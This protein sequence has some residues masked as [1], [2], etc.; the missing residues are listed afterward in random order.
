MRNRLLG[1]LVHGRNEFIRVLA[2]PHQAHPLR[3]LLQRRRQRYFHLGV[4]GETAGHPEL[5]DGRRGPLVQCPLD[6]AG[7][8]LI[9]KVRKSNGECGSGKDAAEQ[10]RK[11]DE[12]QQRRRFDGIVPFSLVRR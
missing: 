10:P 12:A 6:A 1:G 8:I 11:S 7:G 3:D 5:I 4:V 2:P 9:G